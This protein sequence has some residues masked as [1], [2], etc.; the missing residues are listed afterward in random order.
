MASS[1]L[2]KLIRNQTR[3]ASTFFTHFHKPPSPFAPTQIPKPNDP[4]PEFIPKNPFFAQVYPTF[5]FEFLLNPL[6]LSKLIRPESDGE[7]DGSNIGE[8]L[9][10]YDHSTLLDEGIRPHGY[11]LTGEWELI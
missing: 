11:A 8:K 10:Q 5:S 1:T 4:T 3:P 2:Q 9:A 7:A 6:S